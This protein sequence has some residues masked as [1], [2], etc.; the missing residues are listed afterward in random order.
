[1]AALGT[2]TEAFIVVFRRSGSQLQLPAAP[3]R[4]GG[5]DYYFRTIDLA[6]PGVTGSR[7]KVAPVELTADDILA[8]LA[9]PRDTPDD[10]AS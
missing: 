9:K 1:M 8:E 10:D 5:L 4:A 2:V 3:I 7:A 6:D